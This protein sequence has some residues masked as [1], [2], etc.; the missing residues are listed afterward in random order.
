[1]E[2]V[3]GT[4]RI[5]TTQYLGHE[6]VIGQIQELLRVVARD[7]ADEPVGW[8][9]CG[10][11]GYREICWPQAM[12]Q[13]DVAILI[14]VDQG[15]ARSLYERGCRTITDLLRDYDPDTLASIQRLWGASVKKVGIRAATSV[16]N[17]ARAMVNNQVVVLAPPKLPEAPCVVMFDLEGLPPQVD[18]LEKVFIWGL[19][20]FGDQPSPF[21]YALAF[22]SEADDEATWFNFLDLAEHI[23]NDYGDIPFVHWAA[24]SASI[25]LPLERQ[26]EFPS[27]YQ[28]CGGPFCGAKRNKTAPHTSRC[29]TAPALPYAASGGLACFAASSR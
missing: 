24:C 1:L 10:G 15:L 21:Q 7:N 23:F 6:Q 16:L 22:P 12:W 5:D 13:Q 29:R 4:S 27:E 14:D 19:K 11:C 17:H 2:V 8:S 20:V 26:L 25:I 3:L 28:R 9:K 18:Q